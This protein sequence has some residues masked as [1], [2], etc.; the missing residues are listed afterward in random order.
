MN[1]IKIELPDIANE[2]LKPLVQSIGN[3]LSSIWSV[4]FGW[5]DFSAEKLQF[6]RQ[7]EL[8]S[9]KETLEQ[10]ISKIPEDKLCEPKL[11]IVGPALEASKFYFEDNDLR[12]MFAKLIANSMNLETQDYIQNAFVEIIKQLSPHDAKIL[13]IFNS[14]ST[15]L[16]IASFRLKNENT[17]VYQNYYPLVFL[18][19]DYPE[20]FLSENAIAIIN[21]ERLGLI[22]TTFSSFIADPSEYEIYEKSYLRNNLP[23]KDTT[24]YS[25]P[26]DKKLAI[27][28]GTAS[29]TEY[30]AAFILS[31]L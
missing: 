15:R 31:C 1:P 8:I 3:T 12:S 10:E 17:G 6:K 18:H 22:S 24:S 25:L 14:G 7:R 4:C 30:G 28:K 16:P 27:I 26:D 21:L 29:L 9:F 23:G 20:R 2:G 19:K 5:I 13:R 11:S